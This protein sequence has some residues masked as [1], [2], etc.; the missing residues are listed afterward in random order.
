MQRRW[1]RA[2][3]A[4]AVVDVGVDVVMPAVM[5][6]AVVIAAH[7]VAHTDVV[8][9]LPSTVAVT[10]SAAPSCFSRASAVDSQSV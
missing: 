5:L 10:D 3:V 9:C 4:A 8:W 1:G 2:A 7:V 6:V